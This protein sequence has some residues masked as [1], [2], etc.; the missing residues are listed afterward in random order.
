MASRR[1]LVD[2][3]K[4]AM[5]G[6]DGN[7]RYVLELLR[8]LRQ[9]VESGTLDWRIDVYVGR[10][11]ILALETPNL[12]EEAARSRPRSAQRKTLGARATSEARMVRRSLRRGLTD[13]NRTCNRV[14]TH[15]RDVLVATAQSVLPDA[16]YVSLIRWK[17]RLWGQRSRGEVR[18]PLGIGYDLVHLTLPTSYQ[19]FRRTTTPLITTVHD[20]CHLRMPESMERR[21]RVA[22]ARGLRHLVRQGAHFIAV[23]ETTRTEM[24]GAYSIDPE[25]VCTIHEACNTER[26]FPVRDVASVDEVR[27]R[28]RLPP[29]PYLLSLCTL[30]PRKNLMHTVRAFNQLTAAQP[31]LDTSL[32]VAGPEGWKIGELLRASGLKRSRVHL[33]GF[34]DEDD[35]P[36][37][38]SGALGLVYVSHYEGFG[39]PLLEA[40]SCGTPVIFG[41]NSSM[42]EIVGPGGLPA[43]ADDVDDIMR[44][45]RRLI[46]DASLR[47]ELAERALARGAEFSW[48]RTVDA[49][50]AAYDRRL[51]EPGS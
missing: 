42:P 26:F 11:R 51:K 33:T 6:M 47:R 36:A 18:W 28:Y 20:L 16:A 10:H 29:G 48:E 31:T 19:M 7:K 50:I 43:R 14:Y 37:L 22:L 49:T 41:H 35:L 44:Q 17:R 23:S 30:E 25:R 38:Y 21:N 5:G 34:I 1:L 13:A 40:M 9:R 24:L 3:S 8:G 27:R 15:G 2:A 4:L 46:H 45:M 39:L 12:L 32:I